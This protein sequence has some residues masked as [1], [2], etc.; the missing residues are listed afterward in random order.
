LG[1]LEPLFEGA[2]P[3]KALRGDGTVYIVLENSAHICEAFLLI[4]SCYTIV[5]D[6]VFEN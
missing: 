4:K 2:K 5:P 3:T 1:G 6:G